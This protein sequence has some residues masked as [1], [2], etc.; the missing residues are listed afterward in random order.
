MILL[1]KSL[2]YILLN[3][4]RMQNNELEECIDDERQ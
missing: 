1:T 2:Y 4:N 3:I